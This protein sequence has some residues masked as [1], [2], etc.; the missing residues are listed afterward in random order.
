MSDFA[1]LGAADS[2]YF[3]CC[4][5]NGKHAEAVA[6]ELLPERWLDEHGD[7]LYRYA[8]L[9]PGNPAL[10]ECLLQDVRVACLTVLRRD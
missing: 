10:A 6:T 2:G 7:H 4:S 8:L 1:A 3:V 9:Q 5:F